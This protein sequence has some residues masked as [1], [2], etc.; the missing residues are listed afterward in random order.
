MNRTS[1]QRADS[2]GMP[3]R[4]VLQHFGLIALRH[5]HPPLRTHLKKGSMWGSTS[6][7]RNEN[8]IKL[9]RDWYFCS[10]HENLGRGH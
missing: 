9:N 10:T 8:S 4:W 2:V 3:Q 6:A 1:A 5:Q 7:E